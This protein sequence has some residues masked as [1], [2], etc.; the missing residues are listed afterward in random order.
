[1]EI[2]ERMAKAD[3]HSTIHFIETY[4]SILQTAPYRTT[5]VNKITLLYGCY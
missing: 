3:K 5:A 1:M 4:P 2:F